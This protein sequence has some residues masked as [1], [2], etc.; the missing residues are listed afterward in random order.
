MVESEPIQRGARLCVKG[1]TQLLGQGFGARGCPGGRQ[2]GPERRAQ[3][4][5]R[6]A[7]ALGQCAGQPQLR[8]RMGLVRGALPPQHGAGHILTQQPGQAI[9]IPQDQFGL[10]IAGA[11]QGQGG[12]A[13]GLPAA[14]FE[15]IARLGQI[16]LGRQAGGNEHGKGKSGKVASHLAVLLA[17]APAPVAAERL[18]DADFPAYPAELVALGE[19]L[20]TDPILS[21]NRDIACATCHDPAFGTSDGVSLGLGAGAQGAG[22]A[23]TGPN[24]QRQARNAPGLWS[25]GARQ[26]RVLFHDGRVAS[27]PD[28]PA[29]FRTP[30]GA[31]LPRGLSSPLAAQALFPMISPTEMAGRH[32]PVADAPQAADA[33][34]RIAERVAGAEQYRGL[35]A[36]ALGDRAPTI[37]DI[38]NALAAFVTTEFRGTDTAYDRY[39]AGDRAAL[40]PAARRGM[41]LFFG[42]AR[43]SGC[44]AG[45]LFTDQSFYALGLPQFGPGRAARFDPLARDRGRLGVTGEPAD[46]Y[47]FRTPPLRGVALTAPYGHNG[48][49][50]T[51]QG[52]LRQHIDPAAARAAWSPDLLR[53]PPAPD[54]VVPDLAALQDRAEAARIAVAAAPVVPALSDT[55]I[56]DIIAFLNALTPAGKD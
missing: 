35:L 15:M 27:D 4:V 1:V 23:R 54:L 33:W 44:H 18:T 17:L 29:G 28:H 45:P 7:G 36:D 9:E 46:A 50:P 49:W 37:V 24:R 38:A 3:R 39:L 55:D 52:I 31:R 30:A 47:R 51:L 41:D 8:Q 43:C 14:V 19:A 12:I 22:L 13:R 53:L 32:N 48:A 20:F 5:A 25:L 16:G 34:D 11:R 21:G 2:P 40:D 6:H 42:P 56:A 26:I 10:G